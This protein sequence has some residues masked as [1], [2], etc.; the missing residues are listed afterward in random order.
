MGC[1]NIIEVFFHIQHTVKLYH[2][3]TTSYA[4][5]MA[6]CNLNAT[7]GPLIDQFIEVYMGRYKRPRFDDGLSLKIEQLSDEAMVD[8]I[9]Y[10]V[11]F[12]KNEVPKSLRS[13]DTDLLNIN[14]EMIAALNKTLYLF[15]LN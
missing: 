15:T 10:Y 1:E 8:A 13:S 11:K 3:Q 4:R 7:I 9:Q 12:M 14:D 6:T 5:H 2:W